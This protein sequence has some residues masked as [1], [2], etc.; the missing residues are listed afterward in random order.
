[1]KTYI[2]IVA[3]MIYVSIANAGRQKRTLEI[4][5]FQVASNNK[6]T[7]KYFCGGTSR[8]KRKFGVRM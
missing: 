7:G 1:M 3:L 4:S 6:K 8:Y 5:G 2:L